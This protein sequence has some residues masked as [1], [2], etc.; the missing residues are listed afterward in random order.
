MV[1]IPE[2]AIIAAQRPNRGEILLRHS[3]V[4]CVKFFLVV[5]TVR[6]LGFKAVNSST[7][8]SVPGRNREIRNSSVRKSKTSPNPD[9]RQLCL[10]QDIPGST[11]VAIL[12]ASGGPRTPEDRISLRQYAKNKWL[13]RATKM[14]TLD[15]K[16]SGFAGCC[17]TFYLA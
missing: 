13:T 4:S 11:A 7:S 16:H 6:L 5:F 9:N 15:L 10:S 2:L 14:T 8:P 3:T 17:L 1:C 12:A